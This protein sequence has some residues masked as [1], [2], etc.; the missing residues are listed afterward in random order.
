MDH[1]VPPSGTQY[2]PATYA[3]YTTPQYSQ[4]DQQQVQYNAQV[5]QASALPI[6]D[7]S[8]VQPQQGTGYPKNGQN[9][10]TQQTR[11]FGVGVLQ[12]SYG[13]SDPQLHG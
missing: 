13:L 9:A 12:N 11:A 5:H 7:H 8:R 1:Y 10:G 3:P 6:Q 4:R 2:A